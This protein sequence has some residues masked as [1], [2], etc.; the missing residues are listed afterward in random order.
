MT[1]KEFQ[2]ILEPIVGQF[3]WGARQLTGSF[4]TLEFGK[5]T[6]EFGRVH[7][8]S[9]KNRFPFN[10]FERRRVRIKG[11]YSLFISM[12][13]WKIYADKTELAY[14]ESE[15]NEIKLALQFINGQKLSSITLNTEENLTELKFDLGGKIVISGEW[16]TDDL[17]EMWSFYTGTNK[18]LTYRN[19]KKISY[20]KA[21]MEYGKEKF[22]EIKEK[23][24]P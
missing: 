14:D 6:I 8:P 22:T 11:E 12:S 13:N 16:Y 17:N 18:V 21:G 1:D 15:R 24:L 19:D 20:E 4:L 10:K 2:D 5:P 23:N 3:I 9:E 7:Q